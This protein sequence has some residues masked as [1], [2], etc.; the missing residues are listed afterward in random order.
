ML[1]LIAV[2][3]QASAKDATLVWDP[4]TEPEVVGYNIYYRTDTPT[5]PF[6]GTSLSE[7][8]SPI[9]V[10]GSATTSLTLVL[11][12]DSSLYYFSATAVNDT[13]NESNFSDIIASECPP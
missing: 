9:F 4:N 2:A 6:N 1:M 11:P 5:L 10:D 12:E 8:A 13:Q 7:G 3:T